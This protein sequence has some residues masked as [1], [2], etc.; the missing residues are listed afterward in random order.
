MKNLALLVLAA[1]GI[2]VAVSE[3]VDLP[4]RFVVAAWVVALLGAGWVVALTWIDARRSGLDK[5]AASG[6][7]VRSLGQFIRDF[8]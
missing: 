6:R 8:F 3:I 2:T 4:S 7:G 5:T 1:S